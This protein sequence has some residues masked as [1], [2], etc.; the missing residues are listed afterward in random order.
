MCNKRD[1]L[2]AKMIKKLSLENID[3]FRMFSNKVK[4]VNRRAQRDYH[5]KKI[6]NCTSSKQMF[7]TFNLFFAENKNQPKKIL[8]QTYFMIFSS[9][10]V[11][12]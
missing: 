2:H 4:E 1:R 10:L 12:T 3:C 8:N 11:N 7:Q 6:E 9:I 5:D